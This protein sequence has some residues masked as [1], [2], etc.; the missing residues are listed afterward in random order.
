MAKVQLKHVSGKTLA[1]DKDTAEKMIASTPGKY[2]KVE[3]EKPKK[4]TE[5][6]QDE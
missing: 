1:V 5:K 2:E 4:K 3:K 6:S